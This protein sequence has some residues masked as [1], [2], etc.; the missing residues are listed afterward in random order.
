MRN[1]S[2]FEGRSVKKN[3]AKQPSWDKLGRLMCLWMCCLNLCTQAHQHILKD[4]KNS[5]PSNMMSCIANS[6]GVYKQSRGSGPSAKM[7]GLWLPTYP[8]MSV[9]F[10]IVA[11]STR[12]SPKWSG[13]DSGWLDRSFPPCWPINHFLSCEKWI[14]RRNGSCAR[15]FLYNTMLKLDLQKRTVEPLD[16]MAGFVRKLPMTGS[17]SRRVLG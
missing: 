15:L 13:A 5:V 6:K 10:R 9:L 11:E 17:R 7:A 4:M 2:I 14:P 8:L 1:Q 12:Y 3:I 16:S